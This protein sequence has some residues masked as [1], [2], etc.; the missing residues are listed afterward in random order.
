MPLSVSDAA[1]LFNITDTFVCHFNVNVSCFS[2]LHTIGFM[3]FHVEESCGI[4]VLQL[5]FLALTGC[6]YV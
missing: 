3:H 4:S 6:L 5:P 2:I 1:N